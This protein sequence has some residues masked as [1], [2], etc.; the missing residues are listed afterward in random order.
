[1]IRVRPSLTA[2]M[3]GWT[4]LG[5][6]TNHWSVSIGSITTP[7]RSPKGCMIGFASTSGRSSRCSA[8]VSLSMDLCRYVTASRS[9]VMSATTRSRAS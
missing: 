5:V 3:A 7:E 8:P 4:I 9:A 6:S 2:S 1:M